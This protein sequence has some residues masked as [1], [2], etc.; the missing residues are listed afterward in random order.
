[1]KLIDRFVFIAFLVNVFQVL[2]IISL[3]FILINIPEASD[4]FFSNHGRNFYNLT[5]TILAFVSALH[6]GY[7]IWFLFKYDKYSKSLIPLFFLNVLYAPIYYYRV[8][9][10]KRPLRNKINRVETVVE[11]KSISD[12]EFIELTRQN[13]I[14]ILQLW[15]S[16]KEQLEYQENV[17]TAQVST[18]LFVQWEDFYTPDTEVMYEAF[19]AEELIV[20]KEFDREL[21]MTEKEFAGEIPPIDTLVE[22]AEWKKLNSKAKD[23]LKKVT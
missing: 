16:K 9:I 5:F 11:D 22:T 13:I 23:I 7:C 15:S 10:K 14:G 8:K 1:M 19:T 2:F 6:W 3:P 17:P 18:E 21:K 4:K 12:S 20:L